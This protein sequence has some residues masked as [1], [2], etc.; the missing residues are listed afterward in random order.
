VTHSLDADMPHLI[1]NA[2]DEKDREGSTIPLRADL[3][4]D[5]REWLADKTMALQEAQ[6]SV[7][8]VQLDPKHQERQKRN[9]SDYTACEGQTCLPLSTVPTL[10]T[11]TP[12][13]TVPAGLPRI[14][15]WTA[16]AL[17][18]ASCVNSHQ[19]SS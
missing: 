7:T 18:T 6:E 16:E 8:A 10:S 15:R 11:D 17:R 14:T 5:L 1:L 4:A 9:Q 13:F 2:A 19:G 12:L 3:A